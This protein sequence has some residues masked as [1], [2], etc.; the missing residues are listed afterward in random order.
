MDTL[1]LVAAAVGASGIEQDSLTQREG[2]DLAA[3]ILPRARV[4]VTGDEQTALRSAFP[5]RPG[6]VL[7]SGTGMIC[8]GHDGLGHEAR[9]GGWGWLLD[10]AGNR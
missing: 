9:S 3:E 1:E 10:E 5:D 2:E 8:M 7:I 6:I 4:V